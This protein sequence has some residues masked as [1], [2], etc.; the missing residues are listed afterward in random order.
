M[1]LCEEYREDFGPGTEVELAPIITEKRQ[2]KPLLS[3]G[4]LIF[5][6]YPDDKRVF[7]L[8]YECSWDPRHGVGVKFIDGVI[9][10]VGFGSICLQAPSSTG[11]SA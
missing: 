3:S 4:S 5:P 9:D 1:D 2:L 7:G 11:V 8:L 6:G 10:E